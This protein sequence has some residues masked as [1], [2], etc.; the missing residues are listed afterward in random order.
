MPTTCSSTRSTEATILAHAEPTIAGIA[1]KL[2]MLAW[3]MNE[4]HGKYASRDGIRTN[5]LTDDDQTIASALADA[6]RLARRRRSVSTDTITMEAYL[7]H[8]KAMER[9]QQAQRYAAPV[10]GAALMFSACAPNSMSST[11]R[12]TRRRGGNTPAPS[13]VR[14]CYGPILQ[15]PLRMRDLVDEVTRQLA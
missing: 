2:P 9:K 6:E 7:R 5:E 12:D 13:M 15:K 4:E 14:S 10:L 8:A 1:A 11:S 3:H